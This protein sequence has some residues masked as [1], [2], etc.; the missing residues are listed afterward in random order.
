M[1]LDKRVTKG[2]LII[3][4]TLYPPFAVGGAEKSVEALA[5]GFEASGWKVT[6]FTSGIKFSIESVD[7]ITVYRF[8]TRNIFFRG[9]MKGTERKYSRVIYRLIDEL[10]FF[11]SLRIFR[12]IR[13]LSPDVVFTNNMVEMPYHILWFLGMSGINHVHTLRDYSLMCL[14]SSTTKN[15]EVCKGQCRLCSIG[16]TFR[17][18]ST[19]KVRKVVGVS[20]YTLD[21]HISNGFFSNALTKKAIPNID[22]LNFAAGR[23]VNSGSLRIGFIGLVSDYKGVNLLFEALSEVEFDYELIIAGRE[24][25]DGYLENLARSFN[26][27]NFNYL[28]WVDSADFYSKIDLVV[29][30]AIWPEPYPRTLIESRSFSLPVIVSDSGG[31]SEGV[32]HG[33]DGLVFESGNYLAL[34]RN[35]GLVA[36]NENV[37]MAMSNASG[38][39]KDDYS[40]A[41]IIGKYESIFEL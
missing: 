3:I 10:S 8:K 25:H 29:M 19:N 17:K 33:K 7:G 37:L 23:S 16:C 27:V 31:T 12:T 5:K 4:N 2:H 39:R 6:V 20:N 30:P 24:A 1:N 28:G 18:L 21:R 32:I 11:K 34:R 14:Y 9:N 26:S 22:N 38:L 15:N 41:T 40:E 13:S 35:I 36:K